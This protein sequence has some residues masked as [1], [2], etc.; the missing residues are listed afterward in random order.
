MSAPGKHSLR[1]E[2]VREPVSPRA[3]SK[4]ILVNV[5]KRP[6]KRHAR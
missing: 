2:L 6:V 1:A 3:L 4:T 5:P